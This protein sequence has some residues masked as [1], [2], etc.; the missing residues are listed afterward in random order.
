MMSCVKED[1]IGMA[2]KATP[3]LRRP[4]GSRRDYIMYVRAGVRQVRTGQRMQHRS[5]QWQ[6][7]TQE[8]ARQ[9][10]GALGRQ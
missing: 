3:M 4:P 9:A 6:E 5:H 1:T 2:A 10:S 7:R 8:R